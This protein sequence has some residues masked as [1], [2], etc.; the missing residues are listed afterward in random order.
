M[1]YKLHYDLLIQKALNIVRKKLKTTNAAYIYYERHHIIPKCMGGDNSKTNLVLLTPEEHYLA[2]LLLVRIYPNHSGLTSA[3]INLTRKKNG[4]PVNNKLYSW[5]RKQ[6]ADNVATLHVEKKVGMHNKKHTEET[7][8]KMSKNNYFNNGGKQL[9][10]KDSPL[11]GLKRSQETKDKISAIKKGSTHALHT[12]ET[13]QKMSESRKRQTIT[14]QKAII[15][16]NVKYT[17][18]VEAC[19]VLNHGVKYIIHRLRS[20]QYPDCYYL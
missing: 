16:Y 12:E 4:H 8:Q 14:S 9:N 10:G 17:S 19:R 5:L 6:H 3:A 1:N 20:D 11:Y 2:H 13:K 18:L 7:K 15:I